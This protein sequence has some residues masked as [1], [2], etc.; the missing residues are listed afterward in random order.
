H[1]T[2]FTFGGPILRNSL[3]GFGSYRYLPVTRDVSSQ[4]THVFLRQS[5]TTNNQGFAKGTW[6][7]TSNDT[8]SFTFLNDPFTR[9]ADTD[10]TVPNNRIRRREQGG[11][12]FS[13]TYNRVWSNLLIDA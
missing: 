4:D 1:D 6:K 8:V 11:N 7:A 10:P 3:W 12:N 13:G 9:D 5:K 2:A